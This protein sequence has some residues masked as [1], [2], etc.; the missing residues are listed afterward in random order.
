ME[1]RFNLYS[2]IKD[3]N[4]YTSEDLPTFNEI[5]IKDLVLNDLNLDH[6]ISVNSTYSFVE[7]NNVLLYSAYFVQTSF[8]D[9]I[10]QKVDFTKS[11]LNNTSFTSC[12]FLSCSFAGAEIIGA[13]IINCK[14][15]EC[16]FN[17]IIFSENTISNTLFEITDT[18]YAVIN[19][20]TEKD[21]TWSFDQEN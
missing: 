4:D 13:N 9:C 15:K 5:E 21:V 7:L 2:T 12:V 11:N 17:N 19:D 20:N 18:S 16:N 6:L 14:F 8:Q 1:N 10:F 3:K